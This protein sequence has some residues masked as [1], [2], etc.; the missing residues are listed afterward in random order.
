MTSEQQRIIELVG[1]T[2]LSGGDADETD[3]SGI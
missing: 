1:K 3:P 2:V